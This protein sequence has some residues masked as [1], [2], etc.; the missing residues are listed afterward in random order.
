MR[1]ET[2]EARKAGKRIWNEQIK[3]LTRF[4][5]RKGYKVVF[6]KSSQSE[7]LVDYTTKT[8]IISS[9]HSQEVAFY[10]LLHEI[11]HVVI[12]GSSGKYKHAYDEIWKTFSK[13]SLT[14]KVATLQEELDAWREGLILA[15][16]MNLKVD[17]RK[18]EVTKTKCISTYLSWASRQVSAI[19]SMVII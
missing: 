4:S 18:F 2:L 5:S 16:K 15:H 8:I 1:K 6:D 7:D 11:G 13:S 9:R 19:Q 14:F 3:T 12:K 10:F 17:R